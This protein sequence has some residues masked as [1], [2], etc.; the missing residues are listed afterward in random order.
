VISHLLFADDMLVF[1]KGDKHSAT[2]GLIN[3]LKQLE[4]FTGLSMKKQKSKVFFSKG[5]K[6]KEIISNILG[7]FIGSLPIRYLG[8][9]LSRVYPKTRLFSPLVDKVRAKIDCWQSSTLSFAGRSE[10]I[11]Y[12]L[13][14]LVSYG[15]FLL[16]CLVLY[17]ISWKDCFLTSFGITRCMYG[18][19]KKYADQRK[20]VVLELEGFMT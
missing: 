20:R 15:F 2:T 17:R 12:V 3:S 18:I 7:V 5:C 6:N 4:L 8:L 1:C 9:P 16:S 14:S 13:H 11:K 10:L 19:G